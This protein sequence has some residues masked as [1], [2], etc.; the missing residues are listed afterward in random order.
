MSIDRPLS[1]TGSAATHDLPLTDEFS[2]EL[3]PVQS[4]VNIEVDSVE[5]ALRGVHALEVLLEV[6]AAEIGCEGD[7]LLDACEK[8]LSASCA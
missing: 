5:S 8:C 3:G 6:L 2:A 7:N 4:Q 1:E